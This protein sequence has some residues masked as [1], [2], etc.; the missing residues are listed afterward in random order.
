MIQF[1]TRYE[2]SIG[3]PMT[4]DQNGLLVSTLS[5]TSR[6]LLKE[7]NLRYGVVCW[8]LRL[9]GMI[10]IPVVSRATYIVKLAIWN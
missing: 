4:K 9:L 3:V 8:M 6:R 5:H 10:Y 2:S 7:F 1:F